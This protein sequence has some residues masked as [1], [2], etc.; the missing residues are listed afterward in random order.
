[1]SNSMVDVPI[2]WTGLNSKINA[3]ID[4]ISDHIAN[5]TALSSEE[6]GLIESSS[7]PLYKYLTVNAAM[8]R[9]VNGFSASSSISQ[10]TKYVARDILNRALKAVLERYDSALA[11]MDKGMSETETVIRYRKGVKD[12]IKGIAQMQDANRADAA[13]Y[14]EYNRRMQYFEK[15]LMSR[16]SSGIMANVMWGV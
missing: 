6:I 3:L 12:T 7:F 16:L 5:D 10:L 8:F 1:M 13:D 2:T 4:S 14:Y 11:N 9:G 15:A